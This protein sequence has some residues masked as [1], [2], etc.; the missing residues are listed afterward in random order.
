MTIDKY[1]GRPFVAGITDCYSL[2]RDFYKE[3]F[4]IELTNYARYD[5]WWND[6]LNLY[7]DNFKKEGFYVVDDSEEFLYGDLFLIALNSPVPCHAAIYVGDNKVLHHVQNRLSKIDVYKGLWRNFTLLRIRH[8][9]RRG[10]K[11]ER[12]EYDFGRTPKKTDTFSI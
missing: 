11:P 1:L 2:V 7:V 5:G 3:E 8:N 9:S 10:M 12:K 6:G 4:G